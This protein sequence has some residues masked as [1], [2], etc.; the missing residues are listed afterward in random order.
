ML[1]INDV[2]QYQDLSIRI[3]KILSE[4]IVWIDI[5]D[6]KALPEIISKTEIFHAIESF[7]VF[8]IED[9]FQE[10]ALIQPEKDSTSQRKR[11]QNYN[12]IKAIVDH[13]QFYIPSIRSS[14]I[15]EI[16][17]NKKST[18]QTIYRLLRQYWQRGQ[19]PN[20][21]IPNYQNSG[22]KGSKK[23]ARQKLGRKRTHK[24]GTG[25]IITQEIERLFHLTIS[26]YLLSNKKHSLKYANREFQKLY[27]TL[28][29]D[30]PE[31][32]YPTLRQFQYFY[33]REY[34]QV[35]RLQKRS[36]D[37]EYSK[38]LRQLHSTV[39][40]QV[41]GPGSRYEIDAT[42]A[43]I[44]LVSNLDR[45]R[46]IGRPTIYFVIDVF[47][48]M[49]TGLYIGLENASYKTSIQALYCAFTDKVALCKKYGIDITYENWPC[50]GLPDAILADRAELFGHQVENLEKS[51]SIRLENAPP[52]RGDLKP[53]VES[54]FK[55]IQAE[56]KPFAKGVV[57]DVI[58]KKRGGKDYRLDATLNLD[59]FTKIIL[60]SVLKYNQFHQINNYDRDIDLP[61]DLPA[62]PMA[63]WNWGIQH[64]TGKLRTASDQAVY[65]ALLPREKATLSNRGL[66]LFG[67]TYTC[68]ELYEKGWLHRQN[69]INRPKFLYAAYDPSN[70]EK[71]YVFYEQSS[72]K[73]WEATISDYSREFRGY[74]FWE[75][76]QINSVQKKTFEK[77]DIKNN[78]AQSELEQK[79][80]DIIQQ[81]SSETPL[82]TQS[83]KSRISEIRSNRSH[84]KELER[85]KLKGTTS[86]VIDTATSVMKP[87]ITQ[88]AQSNVIPMPKRKKS[89]DELDEDLKLRFPLYHDLL[90]E[91]DEP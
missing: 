55:L 39:N 25:A 31:N 2:Y 90:S 60:L 45:S 52:Y 35:T 82:S 24:E 57:Q 49:V 63:L 21:L 51:F 50:I 70:A 46:I 68:P 56:F 75:V 66:K 13:E 11:D 42:I 89:S 54:R 41:L 87:E 80:M 69:T 6:M 64:R 84:E 67:V 29:P 40:T 8:R 5:N 85:S 1:R 32:E 77:Q 53:I 9:P 30:I 86:S 73:Y 88:D 26:K 33:H 20:A 47:S 43:D 18:K 59:E 23:V 27:R 34:N 10:I 71:I 61:H 44:Y 81:A 4:H 65:V 28:H 17:N 14:L 76:W 12:L 19:T 15:N 37:I 38:D 83:Q 78:L 79:I 74:S 62:V 36:N 58:T 7:E 91:D 48:R 16:I 22:A 3:L 72:L